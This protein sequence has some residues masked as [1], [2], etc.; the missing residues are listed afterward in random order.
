MGPN[1]AKQMD[2]SQIIFGMQR[3]HSREDSS[4]LVLAVVAI[5][6]FWRPHWWQCQQQLLPIRAGWKGV[7]AV[8]LR[9]VY[10]IGR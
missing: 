8:L 1:L 2:P 9:A 10:P 6:S 7:Q 5:S 4:L 3:R